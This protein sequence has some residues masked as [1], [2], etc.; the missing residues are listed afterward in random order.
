MR[1]RWLAA[2]ARRRIVLNPARAGPL[3]SSSAS[4]RTLRRPRRLARA[5]R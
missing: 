4:G 3:R 5:N 2:G 1:I